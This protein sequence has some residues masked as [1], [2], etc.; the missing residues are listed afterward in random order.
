MHTGCLQ[1]HWH[2]VVHC[3]VVAVGVGPKGWLYLVIDF[4]VLP[5]AGDLHYE[6]P[7]VVG[8]C[9]NTNAHKMSTIELGAF[10]CGTTVSADMMLS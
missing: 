4:V 10:Q 5:V 8:W 1:Q 6:L 3:K 7:V 9:C 2:L